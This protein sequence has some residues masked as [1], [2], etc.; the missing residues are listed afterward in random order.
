MGHPVEIIYPEDWGVPRYY[1]MML[2]TSDRMIEEKP[3]VV[4]RFVDRLYQRLRIC[5][6]RRAAGH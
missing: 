2:I 1:E 5:R 6:R 4:R 3:E